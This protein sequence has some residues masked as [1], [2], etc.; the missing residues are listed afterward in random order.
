MRKYS[1]HLPQGEDTILVRVAADL[2]AATVT[3]NG[4]EPTKLGPD[5]TTQVPAYTT[6]L[7]GRIVLDTPLA[8]A[9]TVEVTFA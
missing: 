3:V 2:S 6:Y 1:E 7:P 8:D 9:A 5:G 4:V